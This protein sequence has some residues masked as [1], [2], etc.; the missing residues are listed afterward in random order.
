MELNGKTLG[1]FGFGNI[2]NEV[3]KIA[4][5]F[6]M[7]VLL[8]SRTKKQT[9][10]P[11]ASSVEEFFSKCDFITIHCPLTKNTARLINEK[12]LSLMKK[13]A[14]LI[15]TSRGGVVDEIALKNALDKQVIAYAYLDVLDKEPMSK[16]CPLLN[17]KNIT[18]TPHIAWA[19]TETRQR[20]INIV[21]FNVKSFLEN[22]PQNVV[23]N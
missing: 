23:N 17:T 5:A 1:I 19:P 2:G 21:A 16:D 12:T 14:V 6:N 3:A 4:Q 15:N 8:Y 18:I 13:S 10:Y 9:S 22:N 7:N 11:Y 20:L